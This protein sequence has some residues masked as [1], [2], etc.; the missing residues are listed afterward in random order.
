MLNENI[1]ALSR[2]FRA[3]WKSATI[4]KVRLV[5]EGVIVDAGESDNLM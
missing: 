2:S 5:A 3:M 1:E 4:E